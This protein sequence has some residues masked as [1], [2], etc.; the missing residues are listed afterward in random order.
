MTLSIT[1]APTD[2]GTQNLSVQLPAGTSCTGGASKNLCLVSFTTAGGFGNC[3][4]VQQGGA[5]AATNATAPAAT[6][7]NATATDAATSATATGA[8]K[9]K[10]P[11]QQADARAYVSYLSLNID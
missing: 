3:V 1:Q 10:H 9:H 2:V 5:A 11:K 4:V 8:H 6:A 7:A